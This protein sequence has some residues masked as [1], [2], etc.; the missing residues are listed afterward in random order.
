MCFQQTQH[1]DRLGQLSEF[2]Q[3]SNT[4]SEQ[5]SSTDSHS[6]RN[7]AQVGRQSTAEPR[8]KAPESK[9]KVCVGRAGQDGQVASHLCSPDA[10]K[11]LTTKAYD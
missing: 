1:L 9:P 7:K 5:E 3:D 10:L 4:G 6:A 2:E 11:H 8:K